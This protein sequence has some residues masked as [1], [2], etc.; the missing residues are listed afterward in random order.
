MVDFKIKTMSLIN[1]SIGSLFCG[2]IMFETYNLQ[3]SHLKM[4]VAGLLGQVT[5]DFLFHPLELINV[6]TKFDYAKKLSTFTTA[7]NIIDTKGIPGF[8]RGGSVTI[9]GSSFGGFIYFS[10]YKKIKEKVLKLLEHR[11]DLNFIA[12]GIAAVIPEVLVYLLYYPFDLIKT[13]IQTGQYNYKN[14]ADGIHQNKVK[15]DI[16]K[17]LKNLYTGFSPSLCLNV[18]GSMLTMVTFEICRDFYANKQKIHSSQVCGKEYFKSCF[19]AGLVSATLL[20]SL[21]VYSIQKIVL[22]DKFNLNM[23]LKPKFFLQSL[24]SGLL[25]RNIMGVSYTIILLEFVKLYGNI[26]NVNL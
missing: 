10:L 12:Y 6:R 9:L 17:T 26:Y 3:N 24:T 5:T 19:I 8:F 22:G 2:Y 11:K 21:E 25:A 14:F 20:N 1:Y 13:R 23:F 16:K 18:S 4:G 15:N 7:K